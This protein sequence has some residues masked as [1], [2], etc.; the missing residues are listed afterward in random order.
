M[1]RAW[2]QIFL[3]AGK[4]PSMQTTGHPVDYCPLSEAQLDTQIGLLELSPHALDALSRLNINKVSELIKLPR[5]ELVR[6]TGIGVK[7]RKELSEVIA[8]LQTRLADEQTITGQLTNT[9]G[10]ESVDRVFASVL[11]KPNKLN[12]PPRSAFL[13]EYLG[14]LDAEA[15]KGISTV[16][17][18]TPV[19]LSAEIGMELSEARSLQEKVLQAWSKNKA[20]TELRNEVEGLLAENGGVMTAVELAE[21]ILLRRGSVQET[22]LRER[23]AQAI[24]RAAIDTELSKQE[25]RWILRRTGN[26]LLIAG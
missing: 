4:T 8:Q 13:N 18:P 23:W 7:T 6:M 5:N 20:I 25:P 19:M 9:G 12:D 21:M 22:P 1:L 14:R 16:H 26:T 10:L 17:W 15:P 24:T 3:L 11:P 2:R